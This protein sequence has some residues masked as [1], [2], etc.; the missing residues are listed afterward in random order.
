[1]AVVFLHSGRRSPRSIPWMPR[2]F[3]P[4][5]QLHQHHGYPPILPDLS[6]S[7]LVLC[8]EVL[9]CAATVSSG[10]SPARFPAALDPRVVACREGHLLGRA[11]RRGRASKV[12]CSRVR[13][14]AAARRGFGRRGIIS[15]EGERLGAVHKLEKHG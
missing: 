3:R 6:P 7:S 11:T 8:G 14:L 4:T 1:M 13:H 2:P 15:G 9:W 10:Y 5:R 12:R